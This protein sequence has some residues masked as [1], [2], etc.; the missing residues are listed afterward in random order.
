MALAKR[1]RAVAWIDSLTD[2]EFDEVQRQTRPVSVAHGDLR[3]GLAA[4]IAGAD[5]AED[6]S[7]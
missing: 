4:Y 5:L 2:D 1:R 7:H 3:S 6:T